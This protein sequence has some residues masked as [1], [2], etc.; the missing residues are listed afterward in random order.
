MKNPLSQFNPF[1]DT[2]GV[3]RVG[4][5]LGNSDLLYGQ[6]HPMILSKD[7]RLAQLLI[8]EAHQ[9][10]LHGGATEMLQYL[11]QEFWIVNG[12]S[13]VKSY[14]HRCTVCKRHQGTGAQQQMAALPRPR[15]TVCPPFTNTGLDYA[16]P[17]NCR[18][19]NSRTTFTKCYAV[20]FVCMATKAVHL[21]VAED[22]SS[23]GFLDVFDRF[24]SRRGLPKTMY[25]DNG[26]AFTGAARVMANDLEKWRTKDVQ[27]RIASH[28]VTWRF[29]TPGAPHHGGL[30]EAAVKSAKKHL[31]RMLGN[32]SIRFGQLL[33]LLARIEACLNSRPLTPIYDDP[34]QG[35]VL[36]PGDFLIGRPLL[37][38]LHPDVNDEIPENRLKYHQR[39]QR[40][41]QHFWERWSK[42]YLQQ[43]QSRSKWNHPHENLQVGEVV[44]IMEN[45]LPPTAWRLGRIAATQPGQDGLVRSVTLDVM[46]PNGGK[47]QISRPIQKLCRLL[48]YS[49]E[50]LVQRREDV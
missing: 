41:V 45:N 32:Q 29:I 9:S 38:R 11:R 5:R 35:L 36:T 30:W 37:T 1:L 3:L 27:E 44:I 28:G 48:D 4:G 34:A 21:E 2:A 33:T 8:E 15:V 7:S 40:M 12:R 6:K 20:V 42:E 24:I 46:M 16:G 25:C 31:V 18:H 50:P 26:T 23:Q 22:L 10:T 47:H 17:F 19:G 49:S 39:L 14:I 13:L 43:L